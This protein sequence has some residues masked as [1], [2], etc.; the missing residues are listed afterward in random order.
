MR[1]NLINLCEDTI[2]ALQLLKLEE[3]IS[4]EELECHLEKKL[5]F[6]DEFK[7]TLLI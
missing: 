1:G 6:I 5:L 2:K 4:E 3:L 7:L